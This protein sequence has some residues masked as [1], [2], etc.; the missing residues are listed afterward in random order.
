MIIDNTHVR[1]VI[2]FNMFLYSYK[3]LVFNKIKELE[4]SKG[5]VQKK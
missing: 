5:M 2:D 1:T 3:I 4:F